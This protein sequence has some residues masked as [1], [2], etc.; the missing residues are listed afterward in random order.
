MS[1]T[2]ALMLVLVFLTAQCTIVTMPVWSSTEAV[3]D[4]WVSKASMHVAR[5][6]LGVAVVNGKIYAIGGSTESGYSTLISGIVDTNEEYDPLT[7]T[8]T[9]KESMPT[10]RAR[11]AIAV[12]QNKI[13][14][15]GGTTSH[16]KETG[17]V[18]TGANE[19]YDPAT[20]TW[21]T[22]S[23]MPTA[24]NTLQASVVNGEIYLIGGYPNS[25]LNE[26]YDPATDSWTTRKSMPSA[27]SVYSSAVIDD[28]IYIIGG[29]SNDSNLNQI[30]S[31]ESDTWSCGA[32]PPSLMSSHN[33]YTAAAATTG[34]LAPKRIYVLSAVST[35]NQ[36]Y[37]PRTDS[38]TFGTDVP[39]KRS[40]LGVAVVNDTLY[41]IGGRSYHF[42]FPDDTAG[43]SVTQYATN[44]QYVPIGYGT[45]D[46][47]PSPSPSPS[48]SA[49]PS[50]SS[51]NQQPEL[52]YTAAA[53]AAAITLIIITA[54]ALALKKRHKLKTTP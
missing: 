7:D 36:V 38:W 46:P 4:S 42:A 15:I 8:W 17:Y 3:E 1:K 49:S 39:T 44:E 13:Y 37:N 33:A 26:V 51:S 35:S 29:Y 2:A 27:V 54:T 6:G 9:F 20:D 10:P 48:P 31:P 14:C 18:Y 30:Y 43:V 24:R 22:K 11:F 19:V 32:S 34:S 40:A 21:E 16:S 28:K 53:T 12:Y 52:I 5:G 25:T 47:A 23:S 45:P 41:A 50:P